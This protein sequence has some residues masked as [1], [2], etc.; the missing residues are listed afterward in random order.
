MGSWRNL[1]NFKPG[2]RQGTEI[3]PRMEEPEEE[4][5]V[6]FALIVTEPA[7]ECVCVAPPPPPPQPVDDRCIVL[8]SP[9][10]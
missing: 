5:T 4:C 1:E 10:F 9:Y 8:Q 2:G 6:V 3:N 7:I